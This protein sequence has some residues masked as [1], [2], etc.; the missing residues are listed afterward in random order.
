MGALRTHGQWTDLFY[1]RT[2]TFFIFDISSYTDVELTPYR[3]LLLTLSFH[4]THG[5]LCP[6]LGYKP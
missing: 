3:L 1:I 6:L 2:D 5:H 4:L